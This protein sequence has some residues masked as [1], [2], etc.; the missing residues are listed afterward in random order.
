M[1]MNPK[2][3]IL[4]VN[5]IWPTSAHSTGAAN[6]ISFELLRG[7]AHEPNIEV[8]FLKVSHGQEAEKAGDEK[9]A[10]QGLKEHYIEVLS[11]L[12][13]PE[14][15]TQ[16][17]PSWQRALFPK[18][19]DFY[20]DVAATGLVNERIAKF[21]PDFVFIPLSESAT[22]LCSEADVVKFAYYSNPDPKQ[23]F[24]LAAFN[25]RNGTSSA[26]KY[27]FQRRIFRQL[28]KFH[29]SIMNK[30]EILANVAEND[31]QYYQQKCRSD[32]F[33]IQNLWIDRVPDWAGKRKEEPGKII[34]SIGRL[35]GTANSHGLGVLGRDLLPEL[36]KTLPGTAYEIHILG[37]GTMHP[38]LR[39]YFNRPEVRLRGYVDD[40]DAEFLS[41][42]VFLSTN[43]AS[44]Y[45]VVHTRYLHAWSLGTCIV[46]HRDSA[47]SMPELVHK[48][49]ALL[50]ND[51]PEMAALV[52]HALKN[53]SLRASLAHQGYL[54]FKNMH[55]AEVVA[56]KIIQIY[57][58]YA[59]RH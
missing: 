13:L 23:A 14:R 2:L 27:F 5:S 58:R 46:A 44:S 39:K 47:L 9:A 36:A 53:P 22:A 48:K 31:A 12:V 41:A 35:D 52:K 51:I 30:Y 7:L 37:G 49:N 20:P 21:A 29:L 18:I 6:I 4:V 56:P 54:D 50:G 10:I 8:A 38:A 33:Y 26:L 25:Y 34:A 55:T 45:K 1:E 24:A 28:E 42:P 43:N 19:T 17:R 59:Q 40:I 15:L 57:H 16:K 3:R 32:A 11:P